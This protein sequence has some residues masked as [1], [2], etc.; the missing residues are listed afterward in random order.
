MRPIARMLAATAIA[1]GGAIGSAEAATL[2]IGSSTEPLSIDPHFS[3][4]GNNQQIAVHIFDSLADQDNN[5]QLHPGLASSWKNTSPTTWVVT[6]RPDAKFSDGNPVTAA[7]VIFSMERVKDDPQQPGAVHR[8]CGEHRQHEGARRSHHRIHHQDASPEFMETAGLLYI[9]EK[10]AAE[11]ES[12]EDFNNGS[13]A[14]GSG[15]YKFKEWVPGDHLTLVRNDLHWGDEAGLR[16]GR[17]SSSSPMT[18]PGWRRLRSGAVDLIDAVPPNDVATLKT[19]KDI[20]LFPVAST[21][22]IYLA[23]DSNRDTSPM[24]T[25][26]DGKPLTP[27]PLKDA[28]VREALS[29]MINRKLIIDRILD[30]AGVPAGQMVGEGMGGYNPDLMPD[31]YDPARR[32]K[33]L[34]EAGLPNGF[35]LTIDFSNDRFPGDGD[36]AQALGQM[37]AR[38]GLKVN[39]V[40]TLPYNVYAPAATK[41]EYSVFL[42]SIGNSTPSSGQSLRNVMMT[43]DK[44]A[45]T[46]SF[47]RGRYSNAEFDATVNAALSEFDDAK[48]EAAARE[49]GR[50]RLQGP[51]HHPA[52]L[53]AGLLGGQGERRLYADPPRGHAR[54]E[55]AYGEVEGRGSGGSSPLLPPPEPVA[56]GH[57][58]AS[59]HHGPDARRRP[60]GDRYLPPGRRGRR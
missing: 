42:Y 28:R 47:N 60:A 20:K 7:D 31:A 2:I 36:V 23:L 22:L 52:L 3:R 24:I 16:H 59:G 13:A 41:L 12:I 29:K 44:D 33:L 11:G 4:T 50:H 35:G 37:F 30:G 8:Q 53:A 45:G 55:C 57:R 34:A 26:L 9:V 46:G 32:K 6:L 19:V 39:A 1:L 21:R 54:H 49:G 38:G 10:K 27:N 5:L 51:R 18:P 14:I 17:S 40:T 25:D 58:R 43:Y 48:R 15:P 56:D